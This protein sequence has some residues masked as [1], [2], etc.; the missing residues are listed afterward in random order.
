MVV[1]YLR[2]SSMLVDVTVDTE[3]TPGIPSDEE[4]PE[5]GLPLQLVLKPDL[6][7]L[8]LYFRF[9]FHNVDL[10]GFEPYALYYFPDL[11]SGQGD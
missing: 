4:V 7:I 5:P 2:L 10:V 8:P 9:L 1:G 6:E 11:M 3:R